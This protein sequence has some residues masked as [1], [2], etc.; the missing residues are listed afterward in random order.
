[1]KI[2]SFTKGNGKATR[3]VVAL[4]AMMMM[5]FAGFSTA[6]ANVVAV[7]GRH[8]AAKPGRCLLQIR[9]RKYIN[10]QCDITFI[11]KGTGSFEITESRK[12][13]Y[14]AQVLIDNDNAQG[15][16][17]GQRGATHAHSSLGELVRSGACWENKIAKIC[18]WK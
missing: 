17:N 11:E 13:G 5:T 15:Y 12:N 7:K 10:G 14:F 8:A 2:F 3:A 9:G 16:W 1:M 4:F 6:N 18:A